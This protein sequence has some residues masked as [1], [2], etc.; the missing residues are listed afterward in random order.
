MFNDNTGNTAVLS[1]DKDLKIRIDKK[2]KEGISIC[3]K[4]GCTRIVG[5]K[6]LGWNDPLYMWEHFGECPYLSDDPELVSEIEKA[7]KEYQ[8]YMDGRGDPSG[9]EA[10]ISY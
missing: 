4:L 5:G 7:C 8:D 3:R 6:C 2:Y 9:K 10:S 1:A